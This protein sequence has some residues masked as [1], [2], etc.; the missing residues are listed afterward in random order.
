V[1]ELMTWDRINNTTCGFKSRFHEPWWRS[2][3]EMQAHLPDKY[4]NPPQLTEKTDVYSL[5]NILWNILTTYT[6]RGKQR[7]EERE[8]AIRQLVANGTLP[9]WPD[10]FNQTTLLTNPALR[11]IE[12]AAKK[13]LRPKPQDRPTA[14]EIADELL[15]AKKNMPDGFGDRETWERE[16]R[17]SEN[18]V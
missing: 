18:K 7:K 12:S 3:E 15:E 16:R 14:G 10:G 11:A 13:C 5:G 2:P 1:A 4:P 8:Y 17:R 6:P 9:S